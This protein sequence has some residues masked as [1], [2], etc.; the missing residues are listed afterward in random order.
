[1]PPA[2]FIFTHPLNLLNSLTIPFPCLYS[3]PGLIPAGAYRTTPSR[4]AASP[5]STTTT[6]TI[7]ATACSLYFPPRV[8]SFSRPFSFSHPISASP[9]CFTI[10]LVP[11]HLPLSVVLPRETSIP[12]V[13]QSPVPCPPLSWQTRRTDSR[14]QRQQDSRISASKSGW[15]Y[16]P[17]LP[18]DARLVFVPSRP[19]LRLCLHAC[20]PSR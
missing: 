18:A 3:S 20:I 13:E 17:L 2:L 7:E 6:A 4:C 9:S 11:F 15:S 8:L 12:N 14:P 10:L 16:F 5:H 1:M 19:V